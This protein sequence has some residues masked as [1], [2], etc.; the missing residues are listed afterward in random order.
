MFFIHSSVEHLGCFH[1]LAN[2]NSAV[3]N[4]GLHVAFQ[5]TVFSGYVPRSGIAGTYVS[6]MFSFFK[7]LPYSC[8]ENPMDGGAW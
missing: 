1:I 3:M 8:L 7:E 5:M 4:I 2:I 6:S